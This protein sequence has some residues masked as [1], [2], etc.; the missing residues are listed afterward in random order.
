MF[1]VRKISGKDKGNIFAMKV[2]KKV[3]RKNGMTSLSRFALT[4]LTCASILNRL[5]TDGKFL[6]NALRKSSSSL[7][8]M[9]TAN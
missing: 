5:S 8:S 9:R 1:Q 4:S 6:Q 3:R 2:L 7:F